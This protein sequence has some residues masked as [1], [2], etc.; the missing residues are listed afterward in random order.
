VN[1]PAQAADTAACC[2]SE[3][4]VLGDGDKVYRMHADTP[5]EACEKVAD[6]YQTTVWAWR[7]PRVAFLVGTSGIEG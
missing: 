7:V 6:L 3:W 2:T 4:D 1:T 5:L